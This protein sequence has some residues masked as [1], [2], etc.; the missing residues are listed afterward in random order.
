MN[1][2]E[3]NKNR[4]T[5]LRKMKQSLAEISLEGVMGWLRGNLLLV[6]TF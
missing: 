6:L 1:I 3:K 2:T 5:T 4:N